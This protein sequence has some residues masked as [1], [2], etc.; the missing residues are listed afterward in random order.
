MR[1]N[2][3]GNRADLAVHKI[4]VQNAHIRPHY[5]DLLRMRT[6][7]GREKVFLGEVCVV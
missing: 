1:N 4:V 6:K 2:A 7:A 3:E 5:R